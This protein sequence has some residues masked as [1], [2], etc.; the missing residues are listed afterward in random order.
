MCEKYENCAVIT[1][2]GIR[3]NSVRTCKKYGNSA[4]ITFLGIRNNSVKH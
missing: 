4:V 2:L 1:F 3:N